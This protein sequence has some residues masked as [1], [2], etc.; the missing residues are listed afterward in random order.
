MAA[1]FRDVMNRVLRNLGEAQ[2]GPAATELTSSYHLLVAGFLN[3]I[4]SE[5]EEAAQWRVLQREVTFTINPGENVALAADTNERSRLVRIPDQ[6]R[7]EFVPLVFDITDPTNSQQMIEVDKARLQ[8]LIRQ[9]SPG[10]SETLSTY[11][12]MDSFSDGTGVP[13]VRL[14]VFPAPTTTRTVTAYMV[15]PQDRLEDDDLDVWIKIPDSVL[16]LGTTWWAYAERGEELGPTN[17][18]TEER[19]RQAL[20]AA[21]SREEAEQGGLDMVP[22]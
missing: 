1:R 21:T 4:K 13:R 3:L 16:E 20:N 19:F 10:Y 9:E 15:V 11:F 17:M 18:F 2:I 12:V 22:V 8:Y 5:I 6:E 14:T 7:G